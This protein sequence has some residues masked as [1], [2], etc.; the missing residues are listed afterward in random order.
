MYSVC[1]CRDT[2]EGSVNVLLSPSFYPI[3]AVV[4]IFFY[5]LLYNEKFL[6]PLNIGEYWT[7]IGKVT[8]I[9]HHPDLRHYEMNSNIGKS[10]LSTFCNGLSTHF[11]RKPTGFLLK[12]LQARKEA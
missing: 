1:I 10:K 5:S 6:T 9:S 3:A 11:C 2:L 4:A 8:Q 12:F 7:V